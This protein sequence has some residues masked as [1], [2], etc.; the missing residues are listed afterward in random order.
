MSSLI[1]LVLNNFGPHLYPEVTI[2]FGL[3]ARSTEI[4]AVQVQNLRDSDKCIIDILLPIKCPEVY[5]CL[6]HSNILQLDCNVT[7]TDSYSSSVLVESY[8]QILA[9]WNIPMDV[10][11]IKLQ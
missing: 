8:I 5:D 10:H 7:P 1:L 3:T 9:Q 2:P 6:G 4:L 11:M